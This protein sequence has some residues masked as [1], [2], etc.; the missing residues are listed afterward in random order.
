MIIAET[1]F[2]LSL[3]KEYVKDSYQKKYAFKIYDGRV[4]EEIDKK[5]LIVANY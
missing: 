1:P 5:H 4:G 2:V 3:Y